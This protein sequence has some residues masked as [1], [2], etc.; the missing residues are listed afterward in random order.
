MSKCK[1]ARK[2]KKMVFFDKGLFFYISWFCFQGDFCSLSINGIDS[3]LHGILIVMWGK[4]AELFFFW[5]YWKPCKLCKLPP[6]EVSGY[7][8]S[9]KKIQG[10][11]CFPVVFWGSNNLCE[12]KSEDG[13]GFFQEMCFFFRRWWVFMLHVKFSNYSEQFCAS[14]NAWGIVTKST[15]GYSKRYPPGN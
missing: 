2:K 12:K 13:R 3:P 11:R 5:G 4:L 8:F 9:T 15:H 7:L 1:V 10:F 6:L 14:R